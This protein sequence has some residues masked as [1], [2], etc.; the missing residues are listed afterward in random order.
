[1]YLVRYGQI[2][3]NVEGP[4]FGSTDQALNPL[5]QRQA[6]KLGNGLDESFLLFT[7]V[8][9]KLLIRTVNTAEGLSDDPLPVTTHG[10]L[11][12]Y[13]RCGRSV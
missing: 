1:M 7:K 9:I 3:A 11:R 10:G 5:G 6:A 2:D 12:E 8:Y 4:W 13:G